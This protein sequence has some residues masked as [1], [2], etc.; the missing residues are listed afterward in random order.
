MLRLTLSNFF[1]FVAAFCI[2]SF[3]IVH[4]YDAAAKIMKHYKANGSDINSESSVIKTTSGKKKY[5]L[6]ATTSTNTDLEDMSTSALVKRRPV[7]PHK[8]LMSLATSIRDEVVDIFDA[9]AFAENHEERFENVVDIAIRHRGVLGALALGMALKTAMSPE[10]S[11]QSGNTARAK[12]RSA[13][14]AKWGSRIAK[15]K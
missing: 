10:L 3:S 5:S 12:F 6:A 9:V 13:E 1:F 2:C 14:M 11:S 8:V 7:E 4:D 15:S